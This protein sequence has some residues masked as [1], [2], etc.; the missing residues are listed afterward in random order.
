MPEASL[1]ERLI[2][3]IVPLPEKEVKEVIDF[4]E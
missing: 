2:E 1:K 4:V 3:D